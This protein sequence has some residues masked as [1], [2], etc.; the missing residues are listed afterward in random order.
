M[1]Y[2]IAAPG[3]ILTSEREKEMNRI[4]TELIMFKIKGGDHYEEILST[5]RGTARG[6]LQDLCINVLDIFPLGG[7]CRSA[8][9]FYPVFHKDCRDREQPKL[10]IVLTP[11]F[12]F[13]K[14][15]YK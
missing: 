10:Q 13:E 2:T 4:R 12:K 9:S 3:G 11:S 8:G 6:L 5:L 14:D 15:G 7:V 1:Y